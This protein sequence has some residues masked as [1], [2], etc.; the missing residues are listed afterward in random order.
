MKKHFLVSCASLMCLLV[1]LGCGDDNQQ[2]A[3]GAGQQPPSVDVAVPLVREITQWDEYT[4][5][6]EAIDNVDIRSRVTGYLTEKKFKDGQM[7]KKGDTLFVI[8]PR[9]FEFVVQRAEAEYTLADKEYVRAQSLRNSRAISQEDLDQRL[10]EKLV[11]EA[12]LND[13]KLNLEF[14]SVKSPINGK[15]SDDFV[16]V[17]NLV[18]ENQTVLTR[19]VS[20]NPIHFVFDAS[21]AELLKYLRLDRSGKRQ[22]SDTAPNPIYIKLQDEDTYSHAGRMD[23]VDN[24]VD[25][26]TGT[27]NG[28]AVVENNQQIIY[29]GLF[30]RARLI[31][32]KNLE[33]MVLPEGAINSDQDR[34][35]VYVV[36]DDNTVQR[37][38][39]KIGDVLDNG[40]IIIDSGLEPNQ[41]VVINGL[42]RIRQPGQPVTPEMVDI[43]WTPMETMPDYMNMPSLD[44]IKS[45]EGIIESKGSL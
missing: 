5:R 45:E 26:N 19:V 8:D 23:F 7:V 28:R 43:E 11:A 36:G 1:L 24:I 12:A 35:F 13:A 22:G 33:T 2:G 31:G 10:Q 30:G 20:A 29:P 9:P 4:G 25:P 40:L 15:V 16:N 44:A 27:I 38:Y 32:Q 34:K 6:F 18:N 3:N 14:T 42:Q 39:V 21:Q 41:K 37:S 17:G